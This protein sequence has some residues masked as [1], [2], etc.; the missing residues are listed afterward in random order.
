M[1]FETESLIIFFTVFSIL[2][3]AGSSSAIMYNE[4]G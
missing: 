2:E 3:S 4:P 1:H